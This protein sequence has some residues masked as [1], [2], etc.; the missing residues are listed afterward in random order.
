[1][2]ERKRI[3]IIY[4]FNIYSFREE[5]LRTAVVFELITDS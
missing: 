2:Y 3:V 4:M 1:M 5:I